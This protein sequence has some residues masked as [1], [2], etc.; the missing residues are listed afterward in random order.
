MKKLEIRNESGREDG[1][2][3]NR[4]LKFS[5]YMLGVGTVIALASGC[6][7]KTVKNNIEIPPAQGQAGNNSTDA[8]T[9]TGGRNTGGQ[10]TS[11]GGSA[12]TDS[13]GAAGI[14]GGVVDGGNAGTDSG[15][16]NGGT[17]SGGSDSGFAGN[18]T[19]S[20]GFAGTDSSTVSC[21]APEPECVGQS[22][23]A[24][25]TQGENMVIGDYRI[26]LNDTNESQGEQQAIVQVSD[27]CM[28]AILPEV[29]VKEDRTHTF[30][31]TADIEIEVGVGDVTV[32]NTKT[33][34]LTLTMRCP[35]QI[36][37]GGTGGT[38][39]GQA[40]DTGFGGDTGYGGETDTGTGG[41][42]GDAGAQDTGS[43]G[44]TDSGGYAGTDSGGYAGDSETG[45]DTGTGGNGGMDGGVDVVLACEEATNA[46]WSGV[47]TTSAPKNVGNISFQYLG[48]DGNGNALVNAAC[49][50]NDV[51]LSC[52]QNED[53][54][55]TT[56]GGKTVTV[57]VY[58][59]L[60]NV[61]QGKFKVDSD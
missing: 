11:T 57:T 60:D 7:D 33:A 24:L 23:S 51:P 46:S 43:G 13:A 58:F 10:D 30:G 25:V 20:G 41:N 36:N 40:G 6:G 52:P 39:S 31:V 37:E 1:Q 19:D 18:G 48:R 50:G 34:R 15:A 14:D 28:E 8:S 27:S 47:V 17:D 4:R 29:A 53:T 35:N 22:N 56:T 42:G 59:V 61:M 38:D 5:K 55:F 21:E 16:G 9:E 26:T 12:G 44:S 2:G 49:E 54:V 32:T 45:G 3:P